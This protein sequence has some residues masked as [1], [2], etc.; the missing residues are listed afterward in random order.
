MSGSPWST[1]KLI[2]NIRSV[3]PDIL[4]SIC[5]TDS[6]GSR[7]IQMYCVC[8]GVCVGGWVCVCVCFV[9]VFLFCFV[10]F[11][12][13]VFL[14]LAFEAS[15]V[16]MLNVKMVSN[17]C[18][19]HRSVSLVSMAQDNYREAIYCTNRHF[20]SIFDGSRLKYLT[21]SLFSMVLTTILDSNLEFYGQDS[22]KTLE[23]Y[24]Q[25][26]PKTLEFYGQ[27][28]PKTQ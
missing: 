7:D 16:A 11:F 1:D 20:I 8:V 22:P 14:T 26:S 13:F 28:S 6:C 17:D 24:G 12:V 4:V 5:P 27:D 18:K 15:Q 2:L 23:F 3:I 21:F 19:I 10:L 9:F 25:D